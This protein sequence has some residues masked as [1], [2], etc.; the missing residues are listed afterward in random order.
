MHL[1]FCFVQLAHTLKRRREKWE[2][3]PGETERERQKFFCL[4][5]RKNVISELT[6]MAFSVEIQYFCWTKCKN[7]L[8]HGISH[9]GMEQFFI[10][11]RLP[12]LLI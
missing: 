3:K 5:S 10:L 4:I 6:S 11:P 8:S 12:Q 1:D 9:S 2:K 7:V